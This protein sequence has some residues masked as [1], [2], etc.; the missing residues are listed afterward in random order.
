MWWLSTQITIF[1]TG[2][3][4]WKPWFVF[5]T[6]GSCCC[7]QMERSLKHP[8]Q[9]HCPSPTGASRHPLA[10]PPGRGRR[11]ACCPSTSDGA[12]AWKQRRCCEWWRSTFQKVEAD[13][14]QLPGG[15]RRQTW[16]LQEAATR[17]Q[18]LYCSSFTSLLRRPWNKRV[19]KSVGQRQGSGGY[20][21]RG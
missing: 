10:L 4:T 6:S 14:Q 9:S 5:W 19:Q 2:T 18:Q 13:G 17:P 20:G 1:K 3:L 15:L 11:G 21:V 8:G 16:V 12:A 7:S